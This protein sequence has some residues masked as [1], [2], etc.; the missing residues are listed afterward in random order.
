MR[1]AQAFTASAPATLAAPP[2]GG[3]V[4]AAN[5]AAGGG[6][7][8]LLLSVQGAAALVRFAATASFTP[9]VLDP[10]LADLAINSGAQ[11]LVTAPNQV[12]AAYLLVSGG[13]L[14]ITPGALSSSL[15]INS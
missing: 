4:A 11:V 5:P 1:P 14:N 7:T 2:A 12:G 8:A 9:N 15:I 3:S 10:G 13:Q 6:A